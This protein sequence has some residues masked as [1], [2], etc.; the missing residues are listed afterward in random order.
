M[1][2]DVYLD[3]CGSEKISNNPKIVTIKVKKKSSKFVMLL[4]QAGINIYQN[5]PTKEMANSANLSP[6]CESCNEFARL[7]FQSIIF[8]SEI[9]RR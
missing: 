7:D 3:P 9:L 2:L 4:L 1:G 8:H 6:V 5:L